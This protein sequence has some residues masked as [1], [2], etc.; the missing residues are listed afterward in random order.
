MSCCYT[1]IIE[2]C[3]P[4]LFM[5]HLRLD[6]SS[7]NHT[8]PC[9]PWHKVMTLLVR[10]MDS[11]DYLV[12]AWNCKIRVQSMIM[13]QIFHVI[14]LFWCKAPGPIK[15]T[16]MLMKMWTYYD[17]NKYTFRLVWANIDII[18]THCGCQRHTSYDLF[19]GPL[20]IL[21][22]TC[23]LFPNILSPTRN[24]VWE[25]PDFKDPEEVREHNNEV[26]DAV[27]RN[28]PRVLYHGVLMDLL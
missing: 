19:H 27:I 6:S 25:I 8:Y 17:N 21:L 14:I 7:F 20:V 15:D 5:M 12:N 24:I 28:I 2:R 9:L 10:I 1:S 3:D 26:Y 18:E 23:T 13:S 22:A 4:L 16:D 11:N